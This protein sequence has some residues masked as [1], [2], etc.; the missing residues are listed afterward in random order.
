MRNQ[1]SK[2]S[3]HILDPKGLFRTVFR[4]SD[5]HKK[6]P[7]KNLVQPK[8]TDWRIFLNHE[9]TIDQPCGLRWVNYEGLLATCLV[10]KL[11]E[12]P[13]PEPEPEPEP[14]LQLGPTKP[15]TTGLLFKHRREEQYKCTLNARYV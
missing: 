10:G 6:N 8:I 15:G 7:F 3:V 12:G 2:L 1:F 14:V 9:M 4:R 11:V 13:E 5:P